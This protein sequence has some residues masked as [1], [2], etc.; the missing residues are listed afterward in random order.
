M[1]RYRSAIGAIAAVGALSLVLAGCSA[2]AKSASSAIVAK[3]DGAKISLW[4]RPGNEAVTDSVVK[5]YNASHKNQVVITHVPADQY[6]TKYAQA[7]QSGSLPDVLAADLVFMPQIVKNGSVLDLTD[8]LKS[9]GAYGNLL[10]AHEEVSTS[11]GR[12]Y[13]VP[14]VADTSLYVYN[15][16]LFKQAGLD[17]NKPPTTWDGIAKDAAAI[18]AL[19]NGNKGFYISGN[20]GG[21]IAYDFSPTIWAQ[22]QSLTTPNGS[23]DFDNKATQNALLFMQKLYKN[24]DIPES[25][26]TDQGDGFFA[27]FASGKIG[28]DF[29]GGNGVNTATLGT[30]PK[31]DFG[32]AAIPGPTN[33][34]FATFSGGDVASITKESKHKNEAWDFIK[35]LTSKSTSEN[36]YF[37]L[38]ALPPRIDVTAPSSLGTQFTVPAELVKH[39]Q[40]Y[41]TTTYGQVIASAQGP[42]LTMFQSVVFDGVDPST[43]TK[44]AQAAANSITK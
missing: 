43:A 18:T 6:V 30:N 44:T 37:K 38:P 13:G 1:N 25:A 21:C 5:S 39:G 24:G 41:V 14:Y 12:V 2:G 9:S 4:V 22:K 32:L 16:D 29:A 28:I 27:V 17:P 31:F 8:L 34:S 20:C 11:K 10:P 35:W 40:T 23:Y 36:V 42:W 15:K 19:G 26:R 7:S 33:G 3:D